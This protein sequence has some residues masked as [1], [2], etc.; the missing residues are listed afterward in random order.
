MSGGLYERVLAAAGGD[1]P[2]ARPP[3]PSASVALWRRRDG[4]LEVYWIRRGRTLQF[5]GGW[6][7]F[8]GGALERDD[9][10]RTLTGVAHHPRPGTVTAPSPEVTDPADADLAAGIVA[11]AL[12]ELEEEVGV[13]L[14]A[15]RLTFAGRW[16]TPAFGALRFDNRFFLAEWRPEDGEPRP[17][18]PESE[19]GGWIRPAAAL[20]EVDAGRAI[21]AP[22]VAHVLRVL[23]EEG[24]EGS[25]RRLLDTSEANLGPLRRIEFRAG[26]LVFPLAAATLPPATHTNTYL[27]GGGEAILVDPG[28][29]FAGE[30]E[31]LLAALEAAERRLG[32]RV[33][34]I[35]LTHHH[36][37]HI[38]GV[39]TLRRELGVPVAAHPATAERLAPLGIP[40]D[41]RLVDGERLRLAGE[42]EIELIVHHTPG[43][44]RGHL[45]FEIDR[46][47]PS[48]ARDLIGGDLV[49]A[50]GTIVIDPPEGDMDDY[51]ATLE[52][53]AARPWRTLL[54]AHGAPVID[55]AG[56]LAEYIAHR[57]ERE[58]QVLAAWQAGL[59]SPAE[60]LPAVYP[61]VPPPA[62]PLAERQVVAHLE[63]LRRQGRIAG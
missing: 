51:L 12:R 22:P 25:P 39:A 13:R 10:E 30:N 17:L 24:P 47:E 44:A 9:V 23:A 8:P 35:W 14:E 15:Y 2:P 26:V 4:E 34:E 41:R 5:M 59:R 52:R 42:P 6:H 32:R 57:L 48:A 16:L 54:P 50:A 28:S 45:A 7:A 20:A 58:G 29:P 53:L 61:E 27:V 56:K 46:G 1:L 63:R 60:F 19:D 62:R 55:V 37:D 49:A 21:A 18:P 33:R 43:H 38:G 3:R 40:I 36:P 31:R 11:C